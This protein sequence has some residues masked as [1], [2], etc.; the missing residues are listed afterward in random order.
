MP[1]KA[2]QVVELDR[3]ASA[4]NSLAEAQLL[5]AWADSLR[6]YRAAPTSFRRTLFIPN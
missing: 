3:K 4:A 6:K 1:T 2:E 5:Q